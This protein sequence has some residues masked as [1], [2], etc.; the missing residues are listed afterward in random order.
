MS[1]YLP[2]DEFPLRTVQKI[3]LERFLL[4]SRRTVEL[5]GVKFDLLAH[6]AEGMLVDLQAYVWAQKL[7]DEKVTLS[8]SYPA[9]WWE[10]FKQQWFPA[11]ALRRWPVKEAKVERMHQFRTMA[12]LPEFKY[13]APVGA[14]HAIVMSWVTR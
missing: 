14:G 7:Q 1:E 13:E 6:V 8:V 9:S 12:L 2:L 5:N 3:A 10:H 11:W 4:S